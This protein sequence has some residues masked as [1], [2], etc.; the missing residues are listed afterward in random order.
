MDNMHT[1]LEARMDRGFDHLGKKIDGV[2]TDLTETQDTTDF[3]LSKTA[4]HEKKLRHY[5]EQQ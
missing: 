5:S 1:D 3:L 4:Q 2:R